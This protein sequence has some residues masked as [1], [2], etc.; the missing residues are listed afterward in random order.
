MNDHNQRDGMI[1]MLL[2]AG[3]YSFF[4]VW[5][6]QL[7]TTLGPLDIGFWRFLVA[8][9]LFWLMVMLLRAPQPNHPLPRRG[10]VVMGFFLALAALSAF[11]GLERIPANTYIVL[12]YT[13]PAMVAVFSVFMGDRLPPVGWAAL[14]LTL[15]GIGLTVPDFGTGFSGDNLIGVLLAFFNALVVAVYYLL[16][17]RLLRGQTAMARASAWSITG[18]LLIMLALVPFRTL[19]VPSGAAAWLNLLGLAT[20]STVLPV[21]FLNAGIQKVGPARAA[22]IGTVEPIL[23]LTWTFFLLGEKMLPL[24]VIG[25]G[26]IL[27]SIILLQAQS[28]R[29]VRTAKAAVGG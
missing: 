22:I 3:G 29:Q 20:V 23:T 11:F 21:F 14:A 6:K 7:Q 27:V 10:L 17:S 26:L 5:V 1:F 18:T 19:Q 8:V 15:V 2:S 25:G 28:L 12:F 9:P 4:P 16:S 13:Y 24:Q